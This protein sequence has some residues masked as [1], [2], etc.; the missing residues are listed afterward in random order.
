[1][2]SPFLLGHFGL[3]SLGGRPFSEGKRRREEMA[4]EGELGRVKEEENV[5]RMQYMIEE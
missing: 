4:G 3:I 2:P 5:V 1:M